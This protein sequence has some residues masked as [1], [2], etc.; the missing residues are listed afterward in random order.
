MSGIEILEPKY[1]ESVIPFIWNFDDETTIIS[2][3]TVT[4][5]DLSGADSS[6]SAMLHGSVYLSTGKIT[7]LIQGGI[8]GITYL[9]KMSATLPSGAIIVEKSYLPII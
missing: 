1:S 3:A 8:V 5:I 6:T 2:S 4:I 7:Q 9:I